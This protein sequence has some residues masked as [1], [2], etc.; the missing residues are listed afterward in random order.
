VEKLQPL[1]IE[2]RRQHNDPG[3]RAAGTGEACRKSGGDRVLSDECADN[4]G[5]TCLFL[6]RADCRSSH[7]DHQLGAGRCELTRQQRQLFSPPYAGLHDQILA[8][9]EA[10]PGE[11]WNEYG[12]VVLDRSSA[13]RQYAHAVDPVRCLRECPWTTVYQRGKHPE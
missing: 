7:R 10:E 11:L 4:R 8:F 12:P 6:H 1:G 9:G 13:R 2:L 3:D 5:S